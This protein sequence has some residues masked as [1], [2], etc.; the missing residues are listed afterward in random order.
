[1]SS[2]C[3]GSFHFGSNPSLLTLFGFKSKPLFFCNPGSFAFFFLLSGPLFFSGYP[4]PLLLF[5]FKSKF[6]FFCSN[7][8]SFAFFGF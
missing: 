4:S 6:L 5:C 3:S 1:L 7:P 2:L 8:G